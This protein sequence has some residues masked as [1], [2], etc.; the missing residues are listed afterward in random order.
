MLNAETPAAGPL[1]WP[2]AFYV[3]VLMLG[4]D[5]V[6]MARLARIA[7]PYRRQGALLIAA[8]LLPCFGNLLWNATLADTGM[9][10][11]TPFLFG[12]T[13]VVLVWASSGCACST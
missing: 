3:Y 13:A 10:D 1:F 12:I 2:H 11:P 9:P 7:P 8:S 4:A 5:F 6:L